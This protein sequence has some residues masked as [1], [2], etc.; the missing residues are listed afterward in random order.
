MMKKFIL[1]VLCLLLW[2][3]QLYGLTL[4]EAVKIAI[5]NNHKIKEHQNLTEAQRSRVSSKKA[6]FLPEANLSYSYTR[7]DNVFSFFQ[8]KETSVFSAE[9]T[10]NLF[11]G[12]SDLKALKAEEAQLDATEYQ[13][14]AI[15]A[16][17]VFE[18]KGAYIE[19][20]RAEKALD[21]AREAVKLLE[22]QYHDASL[23]YREGMIAKNDLL[24]VEVELAS[25]KQNLIKAESDLKV[26]KR[27][28]ERVIGI[29]LGDEK[30][31]DIST[32]IDS[33]PAEEKLKEEMLK[34]R[35]EL[36]YLRALKRARQYRAESIKGGYLPT[37]QLSLVHD[38]YG[39]SYQ[40]DGRP[41][42]YDTQ[43]RAIVIARWNIFDGFRKHNDIKAEEAELR[44]I[45][46][47]IRDTVEELSFQLTRA[48]ENYRVAKEKVE[49]AEKAVKQARENYRITE[50][51]FRQ[52]MATTTDLLDARFFLSRAKNEYISALYDIQR[53]LAE[54]E[55]VIESPTIQ[56][57]S[58][59]GNE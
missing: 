36:K 15:Q 52:R 42:L 18:V 1:I 46:E 55:R 2:S 27:R 57:K 8:T 9:L 59:T 38:R 43:T 25:A 5:E 21:V 12:F 35:S 44:A 34:N 40:P 53:A 26:A 49:V 14:K 56:L 32:L 23:F 31:E 29:R 33:L 50:N 20:L 3:S 48:L 19:F 4:D 13:R 47:R 22:K 41:D 45:E 58:G 39:D 24:K 30:L 10:Y 51:R 37:L 54:I 11:N 17:V 16:D 7:Q 28:L 6:A